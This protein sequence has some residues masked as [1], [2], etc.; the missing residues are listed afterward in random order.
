M[1]ME[2][3]WDQLVVNPSQ[4][5]K[6]GGK[7][8]NSDLGLDWADYHNRWYDPSIGRFVS[9]DK[10]ADHPNQ[11]D[12]S[13]YAYA[14]NDPISLNDPDGNCPWCLGAIIGAAVEYGGQVV[15]NAIDGKGLSSFTDIDVG[16]VVLAGVE[17][18]LTSGGS[19]IRNT[20]VKVAAEGARNL[21]DVN[22][23]EGGLTV[24][25]NDTRAAVVNTGIGLLG[26]VIGDNAPIKNKV[27]KN[28]KS[29]KAAVKK[30]RSE[31]PVNRK[32]RQEIQA[33][34]KKSNENATAINEGIGSV[35]AAG[36][37]ENAKGRV[38]DFRE[39]NKN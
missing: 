20:L 16:D 6:Y 39:E 36:L 10:L 31:G 3:S 18:G 24:S 32:Q 1:G 28:D 2:G 12:K 17:G 38:S 21:V 11:I 27:L 37:S 13:P 22:V 35:P 19:V 9:V 14:W 34:T 5:Y 25:Q 7:E 33:K 29:S 26:G 8:L 30:A 23:E 4:D 15:S